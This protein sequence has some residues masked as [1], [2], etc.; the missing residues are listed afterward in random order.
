MKR[1]LFFSLFLFLTAT[2]ATALFLQSRAQTR[3]LDLGAPVN[4]PVIYGI[5]ID[6]LRSADTNPA[7]E[8]IKQ[9]G[10][11]WVRQSFDWEKNNWKDDDALIAAAHD[12]DLKMVAVLTGGSPPDPA[13]FAA[14]AADFAARYRD[15]ID[16][17]Q[18]WDEPNLE[19]GWSGPPSA[20]EYARLLQTAYA[21][22]HNADPTATVLLAGLAPTIE[23]GPKNIADFLYLRQL[24]NLGAGP[25]FDAV[26]GKPYGFNTHPDDR[27]VD[28]NVLNFSRLILLREEMIAHDDGDKFLWSSHFGW[29]NR[30]SIWGH[31]SAEQQAQYSQQAYDRA[32]N[33]WPWAGPLFLQTPDPSLPADDPQWGF[34]IPDLRVVTGSF[35]TALKPGRYAAQNLT[36][37][38]IF[39][40]G[41]WQFSDLGADIPQA[42]PATITFNFIGADLALT[43][44]RADYR[45]YLFVTIDGQPANALPRD[46]NG[47]AYLILTAPDLLPR[48]ETITLA[49][50]LAPG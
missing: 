4:R 45:A 10:F 46:T 14:F 31:V 24:Y 21:A 37:Y 28:P 29:S 19:S 17:Y 33:E 22:I 18:I 5:N 9:A 50:G 49:S 43:L 48:V 44:R 1:P 11:V 25:Y 39:F 15:Q 40:D 2:A 13:A 7:L 32:A 30:P 35:S 16:A 6:L 20:A 36:A 41:A 26:A 3:G 38:A 47:D 23:A 34:A 12:R 8:E 42:G 27:T